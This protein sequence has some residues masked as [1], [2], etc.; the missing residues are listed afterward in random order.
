MASLLCFV[1]NGAGGFT[2]SEVPTI[3]DCP[4][5]FIAQSS[6]DYVSLSSLG[7]LFQTFFAFD[8]LAFAEMTAGLFLVFASGHA[9]G[10][11]IGAMRKTF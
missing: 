4:T 11:I 2:P 8:D 9:L 3:A 10:R 7:T 1:T 6:V 5:G